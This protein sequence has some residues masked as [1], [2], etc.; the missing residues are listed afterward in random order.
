[1][2]PRSAD[3]NFFM[4]RKTP[5]AIASAFM[6][7]TTRRTPASSGVLEYFQR[8]SKYRRISEPS[9]RA[10]SSHF[11]KIAI[12]S[13]VLMSKAV[14]FPWCGSYGRTCVTMA[15][16]APRSAD[17]RSA[18]GSSR[19]LPRMTTNSTPTCRSARPHRFFAAAIAASA[20]S[21]P[22][23]S[24][25]TRTFRNVSGDTPSMEKQIRSS[26]AD[27]RETAR[28]SVRRSPLDWKPTHP[29][30]GIRSRATR[31]ISSRRGWSSGSP[32][33]FR[34]SASSPGNAGARASN[35]VI[36]RSPSGEPPPS[37][38]FTHIAQLMLQ[39]VVTSTNSLDGCSRREGGRDMAAPILIVRTI[40]H[41]PYRRSMPGIEESGAPTDP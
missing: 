10:F 21:T 5:R 24:P 7:S 14:S 35:T 19:R 13:S 12:A 41:H 38:C 40:M 16:V 20:R 22:S 32:T 36:E 25:P 6:A 1:M 15:N 29:S 26:P 8:I 39:R 28:A 3:S 9:S 17:H 37:V 33:P 2:C 27:A 34:M 30:R 18:S 23:I 11:R 4:S 31:I